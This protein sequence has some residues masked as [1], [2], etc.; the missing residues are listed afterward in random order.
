[1]DCVATI[2][3]S[4]HCRVSANAFSSPLG[5]SSPTVAK[6]WYSSHRTWAGRKTRCGDRCMCAGRR[7]RVCSQACLSMTP[8]ARASAG[9]VPAGMFSAMT[10]PD[11]MASSSGGSCRVTPTLPEDDPAAP[12]A[13]RRRP[14]TPV[15]PRRP[16]WPSPVGV[17][18]PAGRTRPRSPGD[19]TPT[20]TPTAPAQSSSESCCRAATN[21]ACTSADRRQSFLLR[22]IHRRLAPLRERH[23]Q[24]LQ[25]LSH[26]LRVVASYTPWP[27]T[28]LN[29][30][31]HQGPQVR[32]H[33][34]RLDPDP[35]VPLDQP[36]D[37]AASTCPNPRRFRCSGTRPVT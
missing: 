22:R 15:A 27:S 2:G 32:I 24:L 36:R 14:P 19:R 11:S 30:T 37:L 29:S 18:G 26:P 28:T 34:R 6:L 23:A 7:S 4:R 9:L 16:R 21:H 3:T 33:G 8:T 20:E 5:S 13:R 17:S 1:M 12:H 10:V 31:V 35:L 25:C